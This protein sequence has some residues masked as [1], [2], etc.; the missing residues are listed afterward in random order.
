MKNYK[1]NKKIDIRGEV[2]PYTFVKSKL[3]IEE[4]KSGEILEITV[5]HIPAVEN[6]PRSLK[7]EG[8]EILEVKKISDKDWRI[9]V[10]KRCLSL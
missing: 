1:I 3:A 8:H 4:L 6:V 5:D 2:C 10:R 7:D 9:V